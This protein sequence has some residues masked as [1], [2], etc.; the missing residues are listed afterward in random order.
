MMSQGVAT[1]LTGFFACQTL[2]FAAEPEVLNPASPSV[3]RA[4]IGAD[5]LQQAI[6][7]EATRLAMSTPRADSNVPLMQPQGSQSRSWAKRHP[8]LIGALVGFGAGYALGRV[9]GANGEFADWSGE[10][11]GLVFGGIGACTGAII[12]RLT[13]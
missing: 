1:L 3:H 11:S 13:E 12:G 9:L 2:L 4:R 5:V 10:F 6:A 8:V 7:R